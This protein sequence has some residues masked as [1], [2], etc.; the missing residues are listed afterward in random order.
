MEDSEML[1]GGFAGGFFTRGLTPHRI[2]NLLHD[3]QTDWRRPRRERWWSL[4]WH[5]GGLYSWRADA[6]LSSEKGA[7]TITD[8]ERMNE[9]ENRKG[10]DKPI[11]L[12]NQAY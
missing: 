10:S 7:N 12:K 4:S 11:E 9:F 8:L 3:E 6:K 2:W 1:L 5:I